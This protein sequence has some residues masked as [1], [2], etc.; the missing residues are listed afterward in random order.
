ML[1]EHIRAETCVKVSAQGRVVDE[2]C[3]TRTATV[4]ISASG[5]GEHVKGGETNMATTI[6]A[7]PQEQPRG[8]VCGHYGCRHLPV[9][10]IRSRPEGVIMRRQ[11][12]NC[13]KMMTTYERTM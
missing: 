13:G 2:R 9:Y 12:R 1:A 11:R 8:V 10:Y 5:N 4:L 3:G 6:Q 7:A